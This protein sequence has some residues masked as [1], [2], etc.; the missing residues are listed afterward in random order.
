[1]HRAPGERDVAVIASDNFGIEPPPP[2]EGAGFMWVHMV[3]IRDLGMT[4]GE[5]FDLDALAADCETD[6]QWDFFFTAPA[7]KAARRRL[8]HQPPRDQVGAPQT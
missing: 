7:L 1:M 5:M 8:P 3:L 4:L 2:Q 6:G